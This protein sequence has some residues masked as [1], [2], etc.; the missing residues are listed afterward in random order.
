M[1]IVL[2]GFMGT[3]K[4]EV[5]R[6]LATRLGWSFVDVDALIEK[7]QKC[8]ISDI[9]AKQGESKFREIETATIKKVSKGDHSVIA[10]GGGAVIKE[11]NMKALEGSGVIVCLIATA[12]AIYERIKHD[13]TRP[14]LKVEK[15]MQRIKELLAQREP[16]Y[17]RCAFTVDTTAKTPEEIVE[18]IRSFPSISAKTSPKQ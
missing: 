11:E 18:I 17:K 9:F 10:C 16:Y 4:T 15:P 3:G 1:N 8:S 5:G 13:T 6:L 12:E 2:T 14:L 7:E